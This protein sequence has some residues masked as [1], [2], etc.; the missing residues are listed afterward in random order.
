[1]IFSYTCSLNFQPLYHYIICLLVLGFPRP[2]HLLLV[3]FYFLCSVSIF[4]HFLKVLKAPP[5]VLRSTSCWSLAFSSHFFVCLYG[6]FWKQRCSYQDWKICQLRPKTYHV[7]FAWPTKSRPMYSH[8]DGVYFLHRE[9][10]KSTV[11]WFP[12]CH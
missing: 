2:V 7:I 10:T 6:Q 12:F 5:L 8:Q 11:I 1:M 3:P 9:I 4:P